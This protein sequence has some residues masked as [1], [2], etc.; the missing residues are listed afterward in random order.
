MNVPV[1]DSKKTE[2]W[3]ENF[4]RFG[5]AAKGVV[6]L[7]VG[8]LT[9]L[10]AFGQGGKTTGKS[11]ALRTVLEQPFGRVLLGVV[12]LGLLGYVMW[13]FIQAIKDPD[14]K[15]NDTKGILTRVAYAISGLIYLALSVYAI[16]L[17]VGGGSSGSGGGGGGGRQSLVA[18][19]LA[20]PFGQWLVG[21]V[22]LI[23]IGQGAY[24]LYRA[25][26]EKFMKRIK[27]LHLDHNVQRTVKVVG[28]I[29]YVAR[30]VVLGIV[31]YLF[32]RA[33][34]ESNSSQAGGTEEAFSFLQNTGGSLLL[35][36]VAVGLAAY[37]VFMFVRARYGQ[38]AVG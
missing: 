29:G 14:H 35:G 1:P 18:K 37:G 4:A 38:L 27:S 8:V 32:M 22:A 12:A 33:A 16:T 17:V 13:R 24:Q 3:I 21:L 23:I 26:S 9:A 36:V 25:Y 34:I 2:A 7:L 10:A 30:G 15:G 5:V 31:G 11:G 20:Q 6:Y 28:K 19:L